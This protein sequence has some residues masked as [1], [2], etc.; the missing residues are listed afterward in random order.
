MHPSESEGR[1]SRE[2]V[3]LVGSGLSRG[4]W[5]CPALWLPLGV[6]RGQPVSTPAAELWGPD[7]FHFL[8]STHW[9]ASRSKV[10]SL[11]AGHEED[12]VPSLKK[13]WA[14]RWENGTCGSGAPLGHG[15]SCL[16][17]ECL[18][19]MAGRSGLS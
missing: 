3:L 7:D 10:V 19:R 17:T 16:W 8:F 1:R 6:G 4:R 14:W 13:I 18:V 9:G 12:Q 5:V 15:P 11:S 2:I